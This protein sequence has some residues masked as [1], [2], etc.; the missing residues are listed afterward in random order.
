MAVI[1][2]PIQGK[3]SLIL[4]T[5]MTF[6][7]LSLRLNKTKR[8]ERFWLLPLRSRPSRKLTKQPWW[9]HFPGALQSSTAQWSARTLQAA[10]TLLTSLTLVATLGHMYSGV[11]A[12]WF[13]RGH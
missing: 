7:G 1:V 11:R 4:N 9:V 10:F 2:L 5:L 3:T 12:D 6:A 13:S 8:Q